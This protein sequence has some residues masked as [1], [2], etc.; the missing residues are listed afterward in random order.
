MR[1]LGLVEIIPM[2]YV[3]ESPKIT[4]ITVFTCNNQENRD[5]INKFFTM[6]QKY[7]LDV[8]E[9]VE[10]INLFVVYLTTS[11]IDNDYCTAHIKSIIQEL[12]QKKYSSLMSTSTRIIETEIK[13]KN[14][15]LMK[16]ESY[17]Q[18]IVIETLSKRLPNEALI[19]Y[20][21]F[22]V[23][24]QPEFLN[25]VRL[26]TVLNSQVFFPI[27]FSAY[28]PNIVYPTK[29]FPSDIEINKNNGYFNKDSYQFVSFYNLDFI[30]TRDSYLKQKNLSLN[31]SS[32]NL[33]DKVDD[34]Y[35]L[36]STNTNLNLL[37]ATDQSLKCRWSIDNLDC[38]AL[39]KINYRDEMN[40][41]LNQKINGMGTKSELAM[42]LMKNYDKI[43]DNKN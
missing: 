15:H 25:R 39:D 28:A 33:A 35:D 14:E 32:F 1:P 40:R 5:D 43:F 38:N 7:V 30:L 9:Q 24:L 10:R 20:V 31:S 27:P 2:P 23:E 12:I 8:K 41:C 18:L 22:C 36:F 4:L 21:S 11:T 6:Y 26:N 29:P 16:S 13:I 17:K 19:L 3:T 42:H 34:L 37:R